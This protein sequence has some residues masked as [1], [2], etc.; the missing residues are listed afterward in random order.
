MPRHILLGAAFMIGVLAYS[1]H[2]RASACIDGRTDITKEFDESI[3]VIKGKVIE[4]D[5][6]KRIK[7]EYQGKEYS[8]LV[9]R[10]TVKVEKNFKNQSNS[11]ISFDNTQDSARFPV[12]VGKSYVLFFRRNSPADELYVDSCGPS[13][14]LLGPGWK[15]LA[16]VKDISLRVRREVDRWQKR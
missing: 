7:F 10:V 3:Y 6:D 15:V 2:A 9:D 12:T 4:I 16:Q 11:V 13:T 8:D 14:E 5:R 1:G